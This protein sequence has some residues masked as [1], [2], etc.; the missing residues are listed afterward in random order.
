MKKYWPVGV[1]VIGLLGSILL[2]RSYLHEDLQE[3]KAFPYT[4]LPEDGATTDEN[5]VIIQ[6][7]SVNGPGFLTLPDGRTA[8][9]AYVHPDVQDGGKAIIFPM[10]ITAEGTQAFGVKMQGKALSEAQLSQ[11]RRFQTELGQRMLDEFKE[12][13][14]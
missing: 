13:M 5:L 6:T 7:G 8:W 9:P 12:R 11:A 1:L 2:W 10:Q 3:F 14:Q 4:Y